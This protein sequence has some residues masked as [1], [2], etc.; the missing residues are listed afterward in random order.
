MQESLFDA[1]FSTGLFR[2][3]AKA[4]QRESPGVVESVLAEHYLLLSDQ[5]TISGIQHPTSVRNCLRARQLA[6]LLIEEDGS[7]RRDR[8]TRAIEWLAR[9]LY[10]LGPDRHVDAI[11]QI[12]LVTSLARLQQDPTLWAALQRVAAPVQNWVADDLIRATLDLPLKEKITDSSARR[13]VLA[14]WLTHLRQNVGSCFA[15]APAIVVHD[16]QPLQFIIDL[17]ELILTGQLSRVIGGVQHRVPIGRSWGMADLRSPFRLAE[18]LEQIS[19]SP[20]LMNAFLSIGLIDPEVDAVEKRLQLKALL[21]ALLGQLGRGEWD[22]WTDSDALLRLA[23]MDK[24][25]ITEE[26]LSRP[27]N[28]HFG[29]SAR[30]VTAYL[31]GLEKARTAFKNFTENALLKAW[32]FCLASLSDVRSEQNRS[33]LFQSLGVRHD[34]PGGIG[35]AAYAA[36]QLRLDDVNRE[37]TLLDDSFER[38]S[39]T[40]QVAL[41]RLRSATTSQEAQWLRTELSRREHE[42]RLVEDERIEAQ[43]RGERLT[44]LFVQLM[45]RYTNLF[46]SYFQEVYDPEMHEVTTGPYDDSPAGFRLLC[47]YGRANPA[48]WSPIQSADE[49][50]QSLAGFFVATEPEILHDPEFERLSKD[51]PYVVGAIVTHVKSTEFLPGALRRMARAQEHQMA[52]HSISATSVTPWAYISGGSM[53]SLVRHYFRGVDRVEMKGGRVSSPTDLFVMLLDL[54]KEQPPRVTTP[55]LENPIR[56]MLTQSPTHAFVARPG[57]PPFRGGW[58]DE[59]NT[60]TWVRDQVVLP[61]QQFLHSL[62]LNPMM[63]R[64]LVRRLFQEIPSPLTSRLLPLL[65][66]SLIGEMGP[67]DFRELVLGRARGIPSELRLDERIDALLY[68]VLPLTPVRLLR[69]LLSD[70]MDEAFSTTGYRSLID[71]LSPT[72]VGEEL[73]SSEEVQRICLGLVMRQTGQ[74]TAAFDAAWQIRQAMRS[75]GLALPAPIIWADTNWVDRYFAFLV[76]PGTSRLDLWRVDYLGTAGSPMG[77][78]R[79]WMDGSTRDEWLLYTRPEQYT[80]VRS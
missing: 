72:A 60:Y 64:W 12:H 80:S 47:K 51:L 41:Q 43:Q 67:T 30:G 7:L 9:R 77:Q 55:Y 56:G 50:L 5:L 68:R 26:A 27:I 69:D 22:G 8:L 4:E 74:P 52:H 6:T 29:S 59:G 28:A 18:Q 79:R 46:T 25:G 62:R 23:L 2:Q 45:N 32:E 24:F 15:T 61:Q 37:L 14:A 33:N 78:W 31:E 70:L 44:R 10:S 16:E 58:L 73:R 39:V 65:E 71:Q 13:A 40:Y 75:R 19:Y 49:F 11:G 1:D 66:S 36:I 42:M 34:E 20:G 3:L 76:N 63:M 38:V 54:L 17:R 53:E 35:A 48:L 21:V 57:L